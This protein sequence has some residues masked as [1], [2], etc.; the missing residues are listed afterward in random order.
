M[1]GKVLQSQIRRFINE[2]VLGRLQLGVAQ[3][4]KNAPWQL[5]EATQADREVAMAWLR[6]RQNSNAFQAPAQQQQPQNQQA[7]LSYGPPPQQQQQQYQQPQQDP[8]QEPQWGT[9][10]LPR[11]GSRHRPRPR[12]RGSVWRST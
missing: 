1:F 4:G 10:S 6:N 12:S 11:V 9:S 7:P 2:R 8:Q 5:A 3:P